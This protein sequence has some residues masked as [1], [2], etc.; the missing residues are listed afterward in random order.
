MIKMKN[1]IITET[2]EPDYYVFDISN[3]W[4]IQPFEDL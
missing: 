1:E 4:I 3:E 2:F